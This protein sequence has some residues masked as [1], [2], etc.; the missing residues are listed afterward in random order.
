MVRLRMISITGFRGARYPL[1]I[2]LTSGHRSIAIFG[3]NASGKSTIT[4]AIEWFFTDRV[5]HLWKEDCKE[6]SL[7]NVHLLDT[8]DAVV[9]LDFNDPALSSEKRLTGMLTTAEANKSSELTAYKK[10][11]AEERL[12]LRTAELG[13]FIDKSKG[14]K[15]K[16]LGEII[17]YEA[18]TDFRG[19]ITAAPTSLQK[20]PEYI[21]AKS[22]Q[23]T[24]QGKLV[25]LCGSV[26]AQETELYA[27]AM[28]L[29]SRFGVA[30]AVSDDAT[31]NQAIEALTARIAKQEK[32]AKRLTLTQA[33]TAAVN[34]MDAIRAAGEGGDKF[35]GPYGGLIANKEKVKLLDIEQFLTRGKQVLERGLIE[36]GK[37][38][39]SQK[40]VDG[41]H[42]IQ[43]VARRLGELAALRRE[44]EATETAKGNWVG[45][46]AE[47][48]RQATDIEGQ[49][50][51]IAGAGALSDALKETAGAIATL[52]KLVRERFARYEEIVV[53]PE[54]VEST[55]KLHA[56]LGEFVDRV[57]EEVIALE[58]TKE[59]EAIVGA[60]QKLS[61][62]RLAFREYRTSTCTKE[63]F[64]RQIKTLAK[65]KDDFI[66]VQNAAF[67]HVL[68]AMSGD[69]RKYY[70]DLHPAKN[71]NVDDVCLRIIG[72]EGVEF[73]YSFHGRNTYPPA[74]YLS[75]S[76][77]NSLG[78]ALFLASV[79]LFSKQCGFFVLDD[80]V[81]SFD[82]NHRLR[83]LRLLQDEF[84]DWQI[85]ILTHERHWFEMIKKEMGPAG[86]L[87]RQVDWSPENGIQ[88]QMAPADLRGLI[89]LKREQGHDVGN[90]LRT[91]L[92]AVLKEICHS[93][94]VRVPFRFNERNEERT[95]GELLSDLRGALNRK[96]PGLKD[97]AIF[98]RLE[99]SNL[100]GTKGSHDR[101]KEVSAGDIDVALEDI[102]K[103]EVEFKCGK[104]GRLVEANLAIPGEKKISCKCG[105][106]KVDWKE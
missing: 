95:V 59:E 80:V 44:F 27:N 74:K 4:D 73:E 75:E 93:L 30:A 60:I 68:D 23:V 51:S 41:E 15:R 65:I 40:E 66:K 76:H 26:L 96:A 47:A 91:L 85:L 64:E 53:A 92:E 102:N 38:P 19:L 14:E 2:E 81:T 32:A 22:Q 86:W 50:A 69:I 84:K 28:K 5:G 49:L 9:R 70:L 17:G 31:Y 105:V 24:A 89:K 39:F 8:E 13:K 78:I 99:T 25:N 100:L 98:K 97:N 42:L 83:L 48:R 71:E 3:E 55:E 104:C 33:K 103:L 87:L 46:L 101:P 72:D 36:P 82:A 67:Q 37:C 11:A 62:L 58:L 77:L 16:E 10:Q 1:T 106:K 57:G 56:R 79:K 7:R 18:V 45:R 94:E 35:L 34:L 43:E 6:G 21:A 52:E 88:L 61:E 12:V 63:A 20:D 90:D 29:V 54:T